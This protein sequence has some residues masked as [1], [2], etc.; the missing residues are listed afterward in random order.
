MPTIAELIE[1]KTIQNIE[2]C[3]F[4]MEINQKYWNVWE[5]L[6]ERQPIYPID[7]EL[8]C[9]YDKLQD[10]ILFLHEKELNV[11]LQSLKEYVLNWKDKEFY[12]NHESYIKDIL[13]LR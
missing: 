10:H 11:N 12:D 13:R 5:R 9:L 7:R 4:D 3:A 2:R 1:I 6:D 8:K